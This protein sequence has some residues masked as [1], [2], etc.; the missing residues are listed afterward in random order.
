MC[1]S[2]RQ[3]TV[4]VL[5]IAVYNF[6][7]NANVKAESTIEDQLREIKS[8]W[9]TI[10]KSA[11]S[12]SYESTL[13]LS[14]SVQN[15]PFRIATETTRK[16]IISNTGY[17]DESRTHLTDDVKRVF[18]GHKLYIANDHYSSVLLDKN[19]ENQFVI[20][21]LPVLQNRNWHD[22]Q[23]EHEKNRVCLPWLYPTD[24]FN[25]IDFIDPTI[26]QI[27]NIEQLNGDLINIK[28]RPRDGLANSDKN[29]F[30]GVTS[31]SII[32][33]RNLHFRLESA[34]FN[35]D[36]QFSQSSTVQLYYQ[37]AV[38]KQYF[39]KGLDSVTSYIRRDKLSAT[40]KIVMEYECQQNTEYDPRIFYISHYGLP[41]VLGID[42]PK[43][44][45]P[46]Y[47]WFL[48][49]AAAFAVIAF[50]LRWYVRFR[51]RAT[52]R[53]RIVS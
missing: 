2:Y 36:P 48:A 26:S 15:G 31:G 43:R 20:T 1:Q 12:C 3:F 18:E 23:P 33:N 41:E 32:L 28:F 49:C 8:T 38:G 7:S 51:Q 25:I 37:Q 11:N 24:T 40:S 44:P 9:D 10:A 17:L 52:P 14:N 35:Y 21:D 19:N 13:K 5:T 34:K 22:E 42:P 27:D 47:V 16:R 46:R 39:L 53:S 4:I 6:A 50:L 29:K 30:R 45:T